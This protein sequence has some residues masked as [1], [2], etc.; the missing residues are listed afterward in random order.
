MSKRNEC[1]EFV[2]LILVVYS[3]GFFSTLVSAEQRAEY[4]N[5][6]S[7]AANYKMKI[8]YKVAKRLQKRTK[9]EY[10]VVKKDKKDKSAQI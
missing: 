1:L 9:M 3:L 4:Q 6:S 2:F 8:E 5:G 10:E 7:E